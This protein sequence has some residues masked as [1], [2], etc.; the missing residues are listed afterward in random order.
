MAGSPARFG[1]PS[2]EA[3]QPVKP[4]KI[5]LS[6]PEWKAVLRDTDR[7]MV[8]VE[9]AWRR[10]ADITTPFKE[11]RIY[12]YRYFRDRA[13]AAKAKKQKK[14]HTVCLVVD[15]HYD[16]AATTPA[17]LART[18]DRC[19]ETAR[20]ADADLFRPHGG[21]ST[22]AS[23]PPKGKADD[24]ERVETGTRTTNRPTL[25]PPQMDSLMVRL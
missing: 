11:I 2:G 21:G 12:W 19:I 5:T 9:D 18:F 22:A 4:R 6:V 8:C 3:A 13:L 10:G 20:R 23:K 1:S 17:A 15:V 25:H 16:P 24:Q 14:L 7:M